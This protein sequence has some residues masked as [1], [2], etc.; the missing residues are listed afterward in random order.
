MAFTFPEQCKIVN[1][2]IPQAGNA[3]TYDILSCKNA[4]KIWFIVTMDYAADTDGLYSLV[5]STDVAGT[6]TAAVTATFPIWY[7]QALATSDT[8]VRTTDA[9]SYTI[10]TGHGTDEMFVFEWDPAKHTAGYDCIQMA[11]SGANASNYV[12]C[13]AVIQERYP[14]DP[15]PTSIT[16]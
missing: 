8:L 9:A 14:G 4:H 7:N 5:E 10:D 13:I 15:P 6:T 16:D 1:V 12:S 11:D 3:V 2:A